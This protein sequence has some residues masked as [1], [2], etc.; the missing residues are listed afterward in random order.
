MPKA[1]YGHTFKEQIEFKFPPQP[2]RK[3]QKLDFT[4]NLDDLEQV[5]M[6]V[7]PTDDLDEHFNIDGNVVWV[8]RITPYYMYVCYEFKRNKVARYEDFRVMYL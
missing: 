4:I 5:D 1:L 3:L 2:Q 8:Y 7:K 6:L